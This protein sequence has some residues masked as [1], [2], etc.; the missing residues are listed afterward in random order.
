MKNARTIIRFLAHGLS[1]SKKVVSPQ[2]LMWYTH[3]PPF[4]DTLEE[5]YLLRSYREG[6]ET[7]WVEL[8]NANGELGRW[9]RKRIAAEIR[10]NLVPSA[11]FFVVTGRRIVA[12]AGVYDSQWDG[13]K[14][15]EIGWVASHPQHR[16]KGLG[17]QATAAALGMARSLQERPIFLKTD[18]FRIAAIKIYLQL[19]FVPDFA[20][21]SYEH[22]WQEI[23]SRLGNEFS[24]Y[25]DRCLAAKRQGP[26]HENCH[27]L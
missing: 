23:F 2:L 21:P 17:R 27:L 25:R 19:G 11:Q 26:P 18:D 5:G 22:R 10:G 14:C 20:D 3:Q 1:H 12:A 7:G 4:L 9:S 15:W 8:L 6:D 24:A 16:G 13:N